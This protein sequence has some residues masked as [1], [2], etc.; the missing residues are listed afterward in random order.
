[1]LARR[2]DVQPD[3]VVVPRNELEEWLPYF[4]ESDDNNLIFS[5]HL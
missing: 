2:G 4:S 5:L 3:C 1:L